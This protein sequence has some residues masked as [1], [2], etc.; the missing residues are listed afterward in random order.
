MQ[1]DKIIYYLNKYLYILYMDASH[2]KDCQ[3][4]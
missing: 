4:C 1:N 2:N 3:K